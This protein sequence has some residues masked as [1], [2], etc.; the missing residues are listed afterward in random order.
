MDM[1]PLIVITTPIFLPIVT[2]LGMDPIQFGIVLILNLG[3]GL[4][5][6][7]VGAALFVGCSVGGIRIEDTIKSILP[8]YVHVYRCIAAGHLR[9]P[10][11]AV[12]SERRIGVLL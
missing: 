5:T 9:R 12:V 10:L 3:V 4:V 2:E 1:S 6:P 11:N 8:F 7:P